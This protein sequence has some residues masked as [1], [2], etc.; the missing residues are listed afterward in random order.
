MSEL[1]HDQVI[2]KKLHGEGPQWPTLNQYPVQELS[3]D[4]WRFIRN[5]WDPQPTSRPTMG[6]LYEQAHYAYVSTSQRIPNRPLE[7]GNQILKDIDELLQNLSDN[8]KLPPLE[9]EENDVVDLIHAFGFSGRGGKAVGITN[10]STSSAIYEDK[11]SSNVCPGLTECPGIEDLSKPITTTWPSQESEG[12]N[13]YGRTGIPSHGP[14]VPRLHKL[15]ALLG[16]EILQP[17]PPHLMPAAKP[18]Y[19]RQDY[20]KSTILFDLDGSVRAGT[21]TALVEKLTSHEYG[22]KLILEFYPRILLKLVGPRSP[23]R[24][25]YSLFAM[26]LDRSSMS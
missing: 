19:L 15:V 2:A 4:D 10:T 7:V 23:L 20:D 9:E 17:R 5:C 26:E 1:T 24:V 14:S 16:P 6:L 3:I 21:M 18:W 11:T 22:G 13:P 25:N 12:L 8:A